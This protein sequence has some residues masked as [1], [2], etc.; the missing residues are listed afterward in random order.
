LTLIEIPAGAFC[1]LAAIGNFAVEGTTQ[2]GGYIALL[3]SVG[4]T[5][6]AVA[7]RSSPDTA[8]KSSQA[9]SPPQDDKPQATD[10]EP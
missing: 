8:G 2:L 1:L 7:A 5:A 10:L 4:W 6:S 9:E 3:A